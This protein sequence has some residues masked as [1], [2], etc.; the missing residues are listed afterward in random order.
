VV[1]IALVAAAV[2]WFTRERITLPES[3]DGVTLYT[4]P[5]TEAGVDQ[6]HSFIDAQGIEGD[7]AFYASAGTPRSALIWIRDPSRTDS[8]AAF[9]AFASGFGP[10]L[11]GGAVGTEQLDRTAVG[12]IT[13]LCAPVSGSI[14][15]AIC[16]WKDG[17]IFWV[18]FD[19]GQGAGVESTRDLAVRA[20]AAVA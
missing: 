14:P 9:E 8:E 11:G 20:T 4:S 17:E 6:F 5:Q 16:F 18:L 13:Y 12:A 2:W 3:F 1:A 15:G 19:A 7:M 10:A